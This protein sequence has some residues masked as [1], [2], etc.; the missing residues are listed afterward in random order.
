M[1][2]AVEFGRQDIDKMK[3]DVRT[4]KGNIGSIKGEIAILQDKIK[5]I[6]VAIEK[7]NNDAVALAQSGNDALAEQHIN[8][9]MSLEPQLENLKVAI[10]TQEGILKDQIKNKD[11]LQAAIDQAEADL[12][13]TKAMVDAAKANENLAQISTSSGKSA[14]AAS[15]ERQEEARK[16]LIRSQVLKE[17]GS[18]DTSLEAATAAALSKN[19]AKDRLAQLMQKK[20]AG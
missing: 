18:A 16:R 11:E 14:L 7:H 19:Q 10:E 9:A 3:T 6:E 15:K 2:N 1:D 20:A 4:I 12:V 17:E 5:G 13:T 8:K